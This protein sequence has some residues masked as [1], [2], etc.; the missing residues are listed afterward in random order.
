VDFK[1]LREDADGGGCV[2]QCVLG[3]AHLYGFGID[4]NYDEAFRLLSAASEQG[5]SRATLGL[6]YMYANGMGRPVN[7]HQAIRH[8]EAVAALSDSSDAFAARITLARIYSRSDGP[9]ASRDLAQYW[10][11]A[12]L[13]LRDDQDNSEDVVEAKRYI[14][15]TT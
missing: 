10:Y 12:A 4:V 6:G 3:L 9:G 13:K 14:A 11:S 7:I 1:K 8:L 2:S 15:A 5:S